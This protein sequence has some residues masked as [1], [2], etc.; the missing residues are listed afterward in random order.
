MAD[1]LPTELDYDEIDRLVEDDS[2]SV[3][4]RKKATV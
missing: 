4:K 2:L 3:S 1:A